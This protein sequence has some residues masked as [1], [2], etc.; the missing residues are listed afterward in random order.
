MKDKI[1]LVLKIVVLI[2]LFVWIVIVFSDY[3]RVRQEKNPMFCI[4]EEE[5]EYNDG[6]TYI[7]KGIGYKVI[8][9]N[10]EC[11]AARQFGPFFVQEKVCSIND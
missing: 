2:I 11:L 7:C 10:R 4:S 3:F 1:M 5:H 6:T 8:Y 9:Y